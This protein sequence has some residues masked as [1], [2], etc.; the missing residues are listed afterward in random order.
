[1]LDIFEKSLLISGDKYLK[2]KKTSNEKKYIKFKENLLNKLAITED[3]NDTYMR[4]NNFYKDDSVDLIIK[5]PD[6]LEESDYH[7][8]NK[9][10]TKIC[11]DLMAFKLNNIFKGL[12]EYH[13]N[14]NF[15]KITIQSINFYNFNYPFKVSD[16]NTIIDSIYRNTN[17]ILNNPEV[18]LEVEF[19]YFKEN[20]NLIE[21]FKN[22]SITRYSIANFDFYNEFDKPNIKILNSIK[23]AD[24][25]TKNLN[26]DLVIN[27]FDLVNDSYEYFE[28]FK[29]F[30]KK[31]DLEL[32]CSHLSLYADELD[33]F[34]DEYPTKASNIIKMANEELNYLLIKRN[35]LK[36]D[37]FH[38]T[39]ID[40]LPSVHLNNLKNNK[41]YIGFGYDVSSR[42][43]GYVGMY[44]MQRKSKKELKSSLNN[45]GISN[46]LMETIID[47]LSYKSSFKFIPEEINF[48][49]I[50]EL[51]NI[52]TSHSPFTLYSIEELVINYITFNNLEIH[53]DILTN[54]FGYLREN[55]L[56]DFY[57]IKNN[58]LVDVFY[59]ELNLNLDNFNFSKLRDKDLIV[60]P[61][62]I[63]NKDFFDHMNNILNIIFGHL[64]R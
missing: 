34:I 16:I 58:K 6:V 51:E 44:V 23:K 53:P 47:N 12:E 32:K 41:N 9:F 35:F 55:N 15:E 46:N 14:K 56:I 30:L 50:S 17:F 4:F 63:L 10:V 7:L 45:S 2:F 60:F 20:I 24:H 42:F 1:M 21:E 29:K 33:E 59:Y 38:Y 8:S 37:K 28:I 27:M 22:T 40:K 31:L 11:V 26:F 62:L 52:L 61:N 13:S 25:M 48:R 39:K 54:L 3:L 49:L 5:F 43:E 36:Y 64:K 18:N 57:N 19:D